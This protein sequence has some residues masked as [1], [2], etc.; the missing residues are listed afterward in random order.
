M[1]TTDKNEKIQISL[2]RSS[3]GI[4]VIAMIIVAVL[5][6][7]ML[8]YTIIAPGFYRDDSHDY[9]W[10][11]RAFYAL[12]LAVA[13]AY[14]V[15]VLY[16]KKDVEHRFSVMNIANPISAA[17]FY[18]WSLLVMYSDYSVTS[19]VNPAATIDLT[20]FM[21]FSIVAPLGFY[22]SPLLYGV[23]V[24]VADALVVAMILSTGNIGLIINGGIFFIFQIVL[25]VNYLRMKMSAARRLV[26]EQE[27][28]LIDVLT[29]CFNRRAYETEVNKLK[30]GT[31]PADFSYIAV[32]L[33]GLKEANDAYGHEAGDR[34]ITGTARC[35]ERLIKGKGQTF[36]TGG[37]EFAVLIRASK[38]EAE[39]IFSAFAADTKVWSNENGLTLSV[40]Y[41]CACSSELSDGQTVFDLARMADGRMYQ[42]KSDY[43]QK[44]GKD[45]RKYFAGVDDEV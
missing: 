15:V 22:M 27:N 4:S 13:I 32:D 9:V 43:Y 17:F 33:N 5:E 37:D 40:S 25:S 7:F 38:Q 30:E 41:G 23:I 12:L 2:C 19:A 31:L 34:L 42:A 14:M 10:R 20:V 3:Q 29:G 21:T 1:K 18:G 35:I 36:R 24:G 16:V 28:A 45:R 44:I 39:D 11:Y 6:L 26:E 8:V